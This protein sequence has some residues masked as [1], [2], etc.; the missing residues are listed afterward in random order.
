MRTMMEV[1]PTNNFTKNANN[2]DGSIPDEYMEQFYEE[3]EEKR[4]ASCSGT[5]IALTIFCIVFFALYVAARVAFSDLEIP[6]E[7]ADEL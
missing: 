7:K 2:N 4:T 5:E 6:N 3:E 1:S